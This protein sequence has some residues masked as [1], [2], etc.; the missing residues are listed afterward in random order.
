MIEIL[1][2]CWLARIAEYGSK[3]IE[4]NTPEILYISTDEVRPP[5]FARIV[6]A[7]HN[8]ETLPSIFL[9]PSRFF[10]TNS[11]TLPSV[12]PGYR[13]AE[14]IEKPMG[15]GEFRAI[16]L[17]SDDGACVGD[18]VPVG[19]GMLLSKN[20]RKFCDEISG[21]RDSLGPDK[22]IFLPGLAD[23]INLSLLVYMGVDLVDSFGTMLRSSLGQ[24]ILN[25]H[26]LKSDSRALE[27]VPGLGGDP[28]FEQIYAHNVQQLEHELVIVRET[29]RHGTL[30]QLV[31]LRARHESWQVQVLRLADRG[32]FE[33]FERWT[34]VE[35]PGFM[36]SAKESLWRPDIERF[37]KR[38]IER[39]LPPSTPEIL[40]LLPCS[41]K[42]PYSRSRTHRLFRE[43]VRR[44][45]LGAAVHEVIV[46][47]PLGIVPRELEMTYPAQQYD[48]P[49][50]GHW[51]EDE[52]NLIRVM[53]SQ[54]LKR[55]DY[56]HIISHLDS[57]MEFLQDL[58]DDA[59]AIHTGGKSVTDGESISAL[60]DALDSLRN[61]V[62]KPEWSKR[63]YEDIRGIASFQFGD[64]WRSI[65][66]GAQIRGRYPM[67]KV[68]RDGSQLCALVTKKGSFALTMEGGKALSKSG[69]YGVEIDDFMP[70]SNIFAIGVLGADSDIRIGD[71]VFVHHGGD[72][73]AVGVA[74]MTPLEMSALN[75]GEAVHIRHHR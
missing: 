13:G 2:R 33:L 60:A 36:A 17:S 9:R 38:L 20:P 1:E 12:D 68:S 66:D 3:K 22:L 44:T 40:L 48:I 35:G 34:P 53:L 8:K 55:S 71:E 54:L 4:L 70:H 26:I 15:G 56:S 51:D 5:D 30:R 21:L 23:P 62:E 6:I 18:I 32:K 24:V 37:R 61:R 73:R 16:Y 69:K 75:R 41:A 7:D 63:T 43:A 46:T 11:E 31:E 52:K 67:I 47:S 57:E 58:L 72:V 27:R 50:T 42:K 29:I 65:F 49:V 59:G 64:A 39:Y 45:G 28:D 19:D 25:G 74:R 14:V 10:R